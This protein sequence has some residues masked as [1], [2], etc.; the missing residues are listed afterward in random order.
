KSTVAAYSDQ[1]A[2]TSFAD[3]VDVIT[4]EFENVPAD[5]AA[6]LASHADVRPPWK[7][8]EIAQDRSKEKAFFTKIGAETPR[9]RPLNSLGDLQSALADI[10]VP[11]ILKTS[12]L[13][14]DGKGQRKIKA[15]G[16]AEAAWTDLTN[17]QPPGGDGPFA[18]LEA[19][20]DFTCE[21]SV[22][23][24]RAASGEVICFEPS[25]NVHA[26]HMLATAT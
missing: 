26:N 11:A 23:A 25:E 10:S 2:L 21:I 8:L 7:A 14:Y 12:R 3:A 19:F 6:F 4:F 15:P 20:V 5:T 22:I 24:A 17:G 13:G 1:A 16:E 18:V 9:W